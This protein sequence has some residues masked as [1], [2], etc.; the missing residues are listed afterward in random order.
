MKRRGKE[1]KK[2]RKISRAKHLD[3]KQPYK[4]RE[5]E[6]TACSVDQKRQRERKKVSKRFAF[7]HN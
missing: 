1:I 2:I 5:E 4:E 6:K 3:N 7:R